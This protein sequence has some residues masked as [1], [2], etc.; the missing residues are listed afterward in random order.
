MERAREREGYNLQLKRYFNNWT[1]QKRGRW[2]YINDNAGE[3]DPHVLFIYFYSP[4]RPMCIFWLGE[5]E[6]ES[7]P[8]LKWYV[9]R[10]EWY[11]W[12]SKDISKIWA[13]MKSESR[14]SQKMKVTRGKFSPCRILHRFQMLLIINL[15][16]CCEIQGGAS[17]IVEKRLIN[18]N[19]CIMF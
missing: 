18:N 13:S 3:Y 1:S 12:K 16:C 19:V 5:R 11:V 17:K 9:G 14:S 15:A 10:G 6:R 8:M 2:C 4:K 7:I